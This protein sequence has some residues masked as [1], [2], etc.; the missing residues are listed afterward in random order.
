MV[1]SN[2]NTSI[3]GPNIDQ[4]RAP[5]MTNQYDHGFK[6]EEDH[7]HDHHED[8]HEEKHERTCLGKC[9]HCCAHVLGFIVL[10]IISFMF[11]LY[12]GGK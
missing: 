12:F 8:H 4:V 6:S 11:E 5:L 9:C 1:H 2:F 7:H 10:V 3:N